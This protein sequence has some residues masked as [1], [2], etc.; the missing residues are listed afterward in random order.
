MQVRKPSVG[1]S[2]PAAVTAD[3]VVNLRTLRG[4][5]R[6]E[7]DE[8]RQHDVLFLLTL[9]PPSGADVAAMSE[10]RTPSAAEKY[11]LVYVRGCEVRHGGGRAALLLL[12]CHARCDTHP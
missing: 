4:E 7:W 5:V 2:K 12:Q 6:A 9:R 3:I 8:L 10:G 11:G 1:D